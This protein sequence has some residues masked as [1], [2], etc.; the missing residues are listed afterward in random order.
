MKDPEPKS[1]TKK[2]SKDRSSCLTGRKKEW[3]ITTQPKYKL[4]SK[5]LSTIN[6]PIKLATTDHSMMLKER[7]SIW[8][9]N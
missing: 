9:F 6:R 1:Y 5:A 3:R 7:L 2:N 8:N 4:S